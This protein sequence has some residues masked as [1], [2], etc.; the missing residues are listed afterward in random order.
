VCFITKKSGVHSGC[1][2]HPRNNLLQSI[3]IYLNFL[4]EAYQGII[5]AGGLQTGSFTGIRWRIPPWEARSLPNCKDWVGNNC[6]VL[7]NWQIRQ[8]VTGQEFILQIGA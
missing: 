5:A 3:S 8:P 6:R 7:K 4:Q 2:D 1:F